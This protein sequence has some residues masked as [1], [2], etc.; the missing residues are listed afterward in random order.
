MS[1]FEKWFGEFRKEYEGNCTAK[2][3]AEVAWNHQQKAIDKLKTQ[4]E[5][6]LEAVKWVDKNYDLY[7]NNHKIKEVLKKL[8]ALE[9]E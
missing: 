1:E 7:C 4:N 5:I 8:K 9:R 6:L 2:A 3:F